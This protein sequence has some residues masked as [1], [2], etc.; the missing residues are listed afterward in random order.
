MCGAAPHVANVD[1]VAALRNGSGAG[2]HRRACSDAVNGGVW[3]LEDGAPGSGLVVSRYGTKA[4]NLAEERFDGLA[5]LASPAVSMT[6][7]SDN[8]AAVLSTVV[9]ATAS[10]FDALSDG[11]DVSRQAPCTFC[12]DL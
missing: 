5:Y 3:V 4:L 7:T 11:T 6:S 10:A 2:R 12:S 8:I 1:V 9:V